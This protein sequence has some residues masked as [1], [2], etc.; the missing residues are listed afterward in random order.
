MPRSRSVS[1]TARRP[2]A[3][4]GWV[5]KGRREGETPGERSAFQVGPREQVCR[6]GTGRG[7]TSTQRREMK[8]TQGA[9]GGPGAGRE[10][11]EAG[12]ARRRVPG[13]GGSLSPGGRRRAGVRGGEEVGP[14]RRGGGRLRGS[15]PPARPS[16]APFCSGCCGDQRQRRRAL[17]REARGDGSPASCSQV[18]AGRRAPLPARGLRLPGP[19]GPRGAR[20]VHEAGLARPPRAVTGPAARPARPHPGQSPWG[21]RV[22][23]DLRSPPG[24]AR[25]PDADRGSRG[26]RALR[27]RRG[28]SSGGSPRGWAGAAAASSPVLGPR[29]PGSPSPPSAAGGACGHPA[30]LRESGSSR[31]AASG[32][33]GGAA[34]SIFAFL[35]PT[36]AAPS[37]FRSGC[38][39][40]RPFPLA[41]PTPGSRAP[42]VATVLQRETDIF[43]CDY[44]QGADFSPPF[45][46]RC[47]LE[48]VAVRD[49]ACRLGVL[50][51]TDGKF[52]II[53]AKGK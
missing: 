15:P 19:A 8:G 44:F 25:P 27:P 10:G 45:D 51:M 28:E 39:D 16:A 29:V 32:G 7:A 17:R 22:S 52:L 50:S 5:A 21:P 49:W 47:P 41:C 6:E 3:A 37:N 20:S 24:P 43:E 23:G 2:R 9:R 12:D 42:L 48:W 35:S 30:P 34:F 53:R 11:R 4:A 46:F 14:G 1:V 13:C 26:A 18:S 33:A 31:R 36:K 40:P 38:S